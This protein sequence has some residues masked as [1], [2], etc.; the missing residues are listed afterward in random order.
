MRKRRAWFG[1][2]GEVVGWFQKRRSARFGCVSRKKSGLTVALDV[3]EKAP[4]PPLTLRVHDPAPGCP[5]A[6]NRHTDHYTDIPIEPETGNEQ[7]F[8]LP[9]E[10]SQDS[11]TA[12]AS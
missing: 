9:D 3:N 2:A 4:T 6:L 12:R 8:Y 5:R 11:C 7:I 1:S 10:Y